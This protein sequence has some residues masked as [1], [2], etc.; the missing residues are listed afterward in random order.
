MKKIYNIPVDK[1][2]ALAQDCSAWRAAS[3]KDTH[4]EREHMWQESEVVNE[5]SILLQLFEEASWERPPRKKIS[6]TS[7]ESPKKMDLCEW[8]WWTFRYYFKRDSPIEMSTRIPTI[9]QHIKQYKTA[10]TSSESKASIWTSVQGFDVH[11]GIT[12]KRESPIEMPIRITDILQQILE[13]TRRLLISVCEG[14]WWT[15]F[16]SFKRVLGK[17]RSESFP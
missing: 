4:Q 16:Y 12:F 8:F 13:E 11:F 6:S 1:W 2:Q 14:Y 17:C 5:K 7:K 9:V 15:F 3:R 10:S